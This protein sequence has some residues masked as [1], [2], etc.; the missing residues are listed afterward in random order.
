[1]NITSER[2]CVVVHLHYRF[3]DPKCSL[4]FHT[5]RKYNFQ[6]FLLYKFTLQLGIYIHIQE[7]V[8]PYTRNMIGIYLREAAM[9]YH[10]LP[11]I[12][13]KL[14]CLLLSFPAMIL[15]FP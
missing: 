1:M 10:S 3:L 5:Y 13:L 15:K 9:F 7:N 4:I 11:K 8:R 14:T 12:V 2:K 6:I